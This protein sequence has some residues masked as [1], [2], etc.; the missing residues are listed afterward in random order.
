MQTHYRHANVLFAIAIFVVL[1]TDLTSGAN[2]KVIDLNPDGI[3][4]S[5]AYG[6]NG[7]QQVGSVGGSG[8][9]GEHA[10]LWNGSA[11]SYVDLSKFLPADATIS[12]ARGIDSYGNIV[13]WMYESG[14]F[15]TV[16]WQ[17]VPEPA[18]LLLL[19]FGAAIVRRKR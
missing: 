17:P 7:T 9:S 11:E 4:D 8:Y 16:V 13:G 10:F 12:E 2:Y 15:H 19:G 5:L 3:S 6:T 18:T 14:H 1:L